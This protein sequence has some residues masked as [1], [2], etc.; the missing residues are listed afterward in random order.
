M[1]DHCSDCGAELIEGSKF[2]TEC[3]KTVE[4]QP[5][6]SEQPQPPQQEAPQQIPEEPPKKKKQ[7]RKKMLIGVFII[8]AVVIVGLVLFMYL[9]GGNSP[10][11][12][13]DIRFVG[14]WAENPHGSPFIW[15]FNSGG[16][17]GITPQPSP[18]MNGTW[19]VTGNQLC[20]YNN[21]VCYTYEFSDNGNTL[22]L[23]RI[24]QGTSYSSNINLTKGV[25]QGTTETPEMQCS[26]DSA[27]N[28]III[29]SVDANVKWSDI[30]ITT[31]KNASWQV[32]DRNNR[33]LA[34]IGVTSTITVYVSAGDSI[35]VLETT[36]DVTVT[37]K[38]KPTNEIIG[39]WTVNV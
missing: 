37:L 18:M 21:M 3:G 32:Q 5:V 25:T 29:T 16:T 12:N 10:R 22:T 2:C 13:T 15:T 8:I 28:R 30:E 23:T 17:F 27:T 20:L 9:Q 34:R 4:Q 36:G 14:E 1:T 31:N 11:S 38:F 7:P 19:E 6:A 26:S 35:L 39:S 33:G 24:G